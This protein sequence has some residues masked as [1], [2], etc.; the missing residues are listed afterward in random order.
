MAHYSIFLPGRSGAQNHLASVGLGELERR[1]SWDWVEVARGPDGQ[2]GVIGTIFGAV[3]GEDPVRGYDPDRQQWAAGPANPE[4]ELDKGAYWYGFEPQR[5]PQPADL[6]HPTV[7][8]GTDV[9]LKDG[10]AWHVPESLQLPMDIGR[11]PDSGELKRYYTP[12]YEQFCRQAEKYVFVLFE[13]IM[14]LEMMQRLQPQ[15][16]KGELTTEFVLEDCWQYCCQA[17]SLNYRV[18]DPLV[19]SGMLDLFD[20]RKLMLVAMATIAFP[21]ILET[22]EKKNVVRPVSVRVSANMTFG[23]EIPRPGPPTGS[24]YSCSSTRRSHG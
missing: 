19:G 2:A 5:P 22:I 14:T 7:M 1:R 8:A 15:G 10:N 4:L 16:P 9:V 6:V 13:N 3:S 21:D 17:L 18:V 24:T 11:D 12:Q 23:D 20:D